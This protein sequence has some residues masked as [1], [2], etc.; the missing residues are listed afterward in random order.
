MFVCFLPVGPINMRVV[1]RENANLL[2]SSGQP[3]PV[4]ELG[5]TLQSLL[6]GAMYYLVWLIFLLYYSLTVKAYSIPCDDISF[7]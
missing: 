3:V 1:F 5:V 6:H 4:N 2:Q 7:C